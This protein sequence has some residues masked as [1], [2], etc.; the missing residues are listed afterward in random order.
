MTVKEILRRYIGKSI[1]IKRY[2]QTEEGHDTE[3]VC[4]LYN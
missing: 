3:E 1:I 4:L 2:F